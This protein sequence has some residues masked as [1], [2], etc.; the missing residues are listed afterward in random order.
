MPE[1]SNGRNAMYLRI[2]AILCLVLAGCG[3]ET[4]EETPKDM[5]VTT[6]DQGTRPQPRSD[7]TRGR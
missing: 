7:R 1:M 5:G 6:P 2:L 3:G 4:N